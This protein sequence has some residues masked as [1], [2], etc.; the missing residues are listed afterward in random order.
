MF[1]PEAR[2]RTLRDQESIEEQ[3]A[4]R[5]FAHALEMEVKQKSLRLMLKP[6]AK[7]FTRADLVDVIVLE[8]RP[9]SCKERKDRVRLRD[10]QEGCF[11]QRKEVNHLSATSYCLIVESDLSASVK[12]I[13]SGSILNLRPASNFKKSIKRVRVIHEE[14]KTVFVCTS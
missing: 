13:L 2:R 5:C 9:D 12:E 6:Y 3:T 4:G 14:A 1:S 10:M 8:A 7:T 11:R